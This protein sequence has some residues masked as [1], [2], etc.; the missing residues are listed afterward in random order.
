MITSGLPASA[1]MFVR[2]PLSFYGLRFLLGVAEAR[3]FP[4]II[5]YLRE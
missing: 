5:Y 3:F 4:G 2:G 1:M